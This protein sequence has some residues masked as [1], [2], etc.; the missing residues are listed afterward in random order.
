MTPWLSPKAAAARP[1]P[2][3]SRNLGLEPQYENKMMSRTKAMMK[4]AAHLESLRMAQ[5]AGSVCRQSW[6]GRT[7][8][9]EKWTSYSDRA[10]VPSLTIAVELCYI[11]NCENGDQ[12]HFPQ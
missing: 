5:S 6:N 8:V 3:G 12:E 1:G 9:I 10:T 2:V 7:M 11:A 4:S